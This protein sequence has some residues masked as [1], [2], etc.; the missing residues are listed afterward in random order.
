VTT[1]SQIIQDAAGEEAEIIFGAVHNPDLQEEIRV[2]VIAT[3]FGRCEIDAELR[4]VRGRLTSSRGTPPAAP[5]RGASPLHLQGTRIVRPEPTPGE[6]PP[7]P[8]L[9]I[10]TFIRRQMD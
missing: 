7:R 1:I 2:T 3:G 8:D 6:D 5:G 10:P 9:D 4:G